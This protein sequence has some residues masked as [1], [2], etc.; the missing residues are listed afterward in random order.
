MPS[1]S[2]S[3]ST[4]KS[5]EKPTSGS[6]FSHRKSNP[7]PKSKP[8]SK[9][10]HSH[11]LIV[12][13]TLPSHV[14]NDRSLFTTYVPSRQ[15]HRTVFGTDI[16]IEGIGDVHVRV[17]MSGK[18][19]LFR[20]RNSWHVPSSQHHFL[21]CSTV[22]SLGNQIM[23]AG[24]SPRMIFSHQKRL[25][26]PNL[27]KYMPF[28]RINNL[29]ALKFD[30]PVPS[31]SPQPAAANASPTTQLTTET[32]L[33]LP[34][35]L[36]HPFAGLSFSRHLLSSP[37]PQYIPDS[38]GAILPVI[39]DVV[40]GGAASVVVGVVVDSDNG[41]AVHDIR[42]V[43]D[44]SDSVAVVVGHGLR[45]AE[46]I[47]MAAG[48][49]REHA[50]VMS[51]MC[52]SHWDVALYGGA[53]V[54]MTMPVDG[55]S[56]S[57]LVSLDSFDLDDSS[58]LCASEFT[59]FPHHLFPCSLSFNR[60]KTN[61]FGSLNLLLNFFD[62]QVEDNFI[63][64]LSTPSF[65]GTSPLS[66]SLSSI[67]NINSYSPLSCHKFSP[68]FSFPFSTST[69]SAASFSTSVQP[70]PVHA[71]FPLFLFDSTPFPFSFLQSSASN[72]AII[73]PLCFEDSY[74]TLSFPIFSPSYKK[75]CFSARVCI[76]SIPAVFWS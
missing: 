23:I 13:T 62:V 68:Y 18:S 65:S 9:S 69:L 24:H 5:K 31:S 1:S 61:S 44:G 47:M 33:S 63:V 28:T 37:N 48:T 20:F 54:L 22:I 3:S 58:P 41:S 34:A 64:H 72:S 49:V 71:I 7:L 59:Q 56:S 17:V 70:L 11:Y 55:L 40:N 4:R 73:P 8:V 26:N 42:D 43:V 57:S 53:D 45:G 27:P 25:V 60:L 75:D 50:D 32:A 74:F 51:D 30:I 21:S 6:P 29:T 15:L 67:L 2:K 38:L 76:S 35:S 16:V 19:I 12:D 39:D 36:Y 52:L 66:R 14:F 10:D 46:A